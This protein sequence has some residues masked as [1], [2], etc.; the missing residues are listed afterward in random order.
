MRRQ[1]LAALDDSEW[2]DTTWRRN[3]SES[4]VRESIRG[5]DFRRVREEIIHRSPGLFNIPPAWRESVPD[6]VG[7]SDIGNKNSFNPTLPPRPF[8]KHL[9]ELFRTEVLTISPYVEFQPFVDKI[10]ELYVSED[11]RDEN[12]IPLHASRSWLVVFYATLAFTAQ[13]IQDDV[14][15]QHYSAKS[16]PTVPIGWDL[17]NAAIFFFGS[18]TKKNTLADIRGA[19]TLAVYYKQVN[20]FGSASIWLGLACKIAQCL[21]NTFLSYTNNVGCHRFSPGLSREEETARANAWWD[22]YLFDRSSFLSFSDLTCRILAGHQ[23]CEMTVMDSDCDLRPPELAP[24]APPEVQARVE[25][26]SKLYNWTMLHGRVVRILRDSSFLS[27]EEIEKLDSRIQAQYEKM[28]TSV[29][30]SADSTLNPGWHLDGHIF[31]DITKLRVFRHNLTP[32]APFPSRLAALRRCIEMAKEASPQIAEKFI[33]A[34]TST[35][36]PEEIQEHNQR[37]VRIIYPEHCQYLYSCAMYLIVANLWS[38][39]LPFVIGLRVIGNKLGI[40]KCCCK[41]LWGVIIFTEGKDPI[42]SSQRDTMEE[43]WTEEAEEV[44]AF[45]GADMHQDSRAWEALWQKG[46]DPKPGSLDVSSVQEETETEMPDDSI[47]I[48][49]T[50]YLRSTSKTSEG[51]LLCAPLVR[52]SRSRSTHPWRENETW[53]SMITYLRTKCDEENQTEDVRMGV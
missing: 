43:F 17:A 53:D 19:L 35:L 25:L 27:E 52:E 22:V 11:E 31:V 18:V 45:I 42:R 49:G 29:S 4:D 7:E 1:Q 47:C 44:L 2:A 26:Q 13:C 28:S 51:E 23:G 41:Y 3:S 12:G 6:P 40:N 9:I 32:N 34:D 10:N 46:E 24:S 8:V 36:S 48:Y 21:G 50:S 37:I 38:L 5:F 20:E 39:V 33:D 16:L 30:Y 15:F 14:I